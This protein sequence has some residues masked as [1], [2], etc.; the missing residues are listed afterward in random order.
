MG[1]SDHLQSGLSYVVLACPKSGTT[2]M[3]KMLS[4]H[5]QVH[6]SETRLFGRYFDPSFGP[7]THLP[8][9][10]Y[11][12]IL[13][14]Y[15]HPPCDGDQRE[16]YF[17]SLLHK[18][19]ETIANH[20]KEESGKPIYG[21]KLTPYVGTAQ[22]VI[23]QLVGLGP[24]LRV[25]HLVRDCRDVIVSGVAHWTKV[26]DNESE[27]EFEKSF[28]YF[29]DTW[30]E[31]QQAMRSTKDRFA[32]VLRVRYEDMLADPIA[33]AQRVFAF[34]GADVADDVIE[35]CVEQ[36][37]FAKLSGGRASGEEDSTSFFRSGTAGQWKE[38][39]SQSQLEMIHS[40]AG[41]LLAEL[42]YEMPTE[43]SS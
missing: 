39:L 3:Q 8:L 30:I 31:T 42:G 17:A 15:Y 4:E 29:L 14:R 19:I 13:S 9:E 11:V 7:S 26:I 35:R 20:A 34:L 5:P 1:S 36:A 16:A 18:M 33:Q 24:E 6:C 37:S 28:A 40:K 23:E 32:H 21:E 2:W 43:T 12:Q 25:I 22:G 27:Q 41:A 38:K 10:E